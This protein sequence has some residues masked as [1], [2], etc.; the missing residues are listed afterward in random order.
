MFRPKDEKESRF[1]KWTFVSLV[2]LLMVVA[3]I[4]GAYLFASGVT[5]D[6]SS[7]LIDWLFWWPTLLILAFVN[8]SSIAS[9]YLLLSVVWWL[10]LSAVI[11][12]VLMI[13]RRSRLE[14]RTLVAEID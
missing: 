2:A 14:K 4:S 10:F 1:F 6:L 9:G 13:V 3:V 8:S 12:D 5:G 7:S 11:A